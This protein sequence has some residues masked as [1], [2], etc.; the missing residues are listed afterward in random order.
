MATEK[1]IPTIRD[2][3]YDPLDPKKY[4]KFLGPN[5]QH[6]TKI[7]KES[8]YQLSTAQQ[9]EWLY[10]NM[11]TGAV[12][13]ST[14]K[15]FL[16]KTDIEQLIKAADDDDLER[17]AYDTANN[18]ITFTKGD[19]STVSVPIPVGLSAAQVAALI[20]AAIKLHFKDVAYDATTGK[21][22][23]TRE[24]GAT[25]DIQ[26]PTD[27]ATKTDLIRLGQKVAAVGMLST[28]G[29]VL[30]TGLELSATKS[31]IVIPAQK[32]TGH[33][34]INIANPITVN[35]PWMFGYV[36][37]TE[38]QWETDGAVVFNETDIQIKRY[39][40]YIDDP[41]IRR[42]PLFT[43]NGDNG[44]DLII[45]FANGVSLLP[46]TEPQRLSIPLPDPTKV[47][48]QEFEQNILFNTYAHRMSGGGDIT[49]NLGNLSWTKRFIWMHVNAKAGHI[50]INPVTNLTIQAWEIVYFDLTDAELQKS[51]AI[52]IDPSRLK[53][54]RY[55]AY[56]ETKKTGRIVLAFRNGDDNTLTFGNG[57]TLSMSATPQK[58]ALPLNTGGTAAPATGRIVAVAGNTSGFPAAG[59]NKD[60][61]A[62][63]S[64]G[65]M[66]LSD[67]TNW[68]KVTTLTV[69]KIP[70]TFSW[71]AAGL[72]VDGVVEQ[73][74]DNTS[75][76]IIMAQDTIPVT[77]DPAKY[78]GFFIWEDGVKATVPNVSGKYTYNAKRGQVITFVKTGNAMHGY[79]IEK[80]AT[81]S[82]NAVAVTADHTMNE[83][84]GLPNGASVT[85]TA[86]G[87]DFTLQT[88]A[89]FVT[90]VD[91]LGNP[92]QAGSLRLK[93][94]DSLVIWKTG[95]TDYHGIYI[96]KVIEYP[97]SRYLH[98]LD[99]FRNRHLKKGNNFFYD[100]SVA[101]KDVNG[102]QP[103][104]IGDKVMCVKDLSPNKE[105]LIAL[106]VNAGDYKGDRVSFPTGGQNGMFTRS[107]TIGRPSYVVAVIR[108][109][110]PTWQGYGG[111]WCGFS[112]NG[113]RI[114]TLT[115]HGST[116]PH[117]NKYP[118]EWRQ[119]NIVRVNDRTAG[120]GIEAPH[121][122]AM[123]L[124]PADVN[125]L[126]AQTRYGIVAFDQWAGQATMPNTSYS[127]AMDFFGL[128]VLDYVPDETQKKEISNY[129]MRHFRLTES[130]P[131]YRVHGAG[132]STTY[133]VNGAISFDG[134]VTQTTSTLP[135]GAEDTKQANFPRAAFKGV[136]DV[137]FNI[138]N[139][140]QPSGG[141]TRL[142]V[143]HR[144]KNGNQLVEYGPLGYLNAASYTDVN[145]Q[146]ILPNI[147]V[148]VGDYFVLT[149]RDAAMIA[150]MGTNI[151]Y[152][153]VTYRKLEV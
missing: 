14:V 60:N 127:A 50:Y 25:K 128:L 84:N 51:N 15:D 88:S 121:L 55:S 42:I 17:A 56:T 118:K 21:M 45:T 32:K 49:W 90:V 124:N 133:A 31:L 106:A 58:L 28:G 40:A 107:Q 23:F 123:E 77:V 97:T 122:W 74:G 2:S 146:F 83:L 19:G 68:N 132:G 113:T 148:N 126:D 141:R 57:T 91:G 129:L 96:K 73:L 136:V 26:L 109:H 78:A 16:K 54:E 140:N 10:V 5:H 86:H 81:P 149:V 147:S 13:P 38:A 150:F 41:N 131:A 37:L 30:W 4:F 64:N 153:E 119:N 103:C 145:A 125:V 130:H 69:P 80:P 18:A 108:S 152:A 62:V 76:T 98:T 102:L 92:L 3:D 65:E 87:G 115:L 117:F 66:Y 1:N 59:S 44:N 101:F 143:I 138:H 12:D 111:L 89:G 29:T 24:D 35:E 43:V 9:I 52:L 95:A 134:T 70:I 151:S 105:D 63:T 99:D 47:T 33:I 67:G 114:G 94:N 142:T 137:L 120:R 27:I 139:V 46:S 79:I 100:F 144:D 11:G 53:I 72:P 135:V 36:E 48:R 116:G 93:E 112:P 110:N 20:T 71:E 82:L 85:Y 22:T 8:F 104:A 6:H 39:N 34:V 61:Y 7:L 75:A